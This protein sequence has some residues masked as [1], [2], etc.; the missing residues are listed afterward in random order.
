MLSVVPGFFSFPT[1]LSHLFQLLLTKHSLRFSN[2]KFASFSLVAHIQSIPESW[3]LYPQNVSLLHPLLSVSTTM[4]LGHA[5]SLAAISWLVFNHV[6]SSFSPG[7]LSAWN[8]LPP[9]FTRWALSS[10]RTSCRSP[11]SK[12][13]LSPCV[14]TCPSSPAPTPASVS[15]NL[16]PPFIFYSTFTTLCPFL[17][18]LIIDF[19]LQ[20]NTNSIRVRISSSSLLSPQ[21]S[22]TR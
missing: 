6:L 1:Q 22:G 17:V 13:A 20:G 10:F 19:L 18:W 16:N 7:S 11:M 14:L 12:K 9:Y 5:L 8:V 21:G 4:A 2:A 3:R 15:L